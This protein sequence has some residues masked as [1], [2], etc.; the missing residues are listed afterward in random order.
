MEVIAWKIQ[1]PSAGSGLSI[2]NNFR[3]H[4]FYL[5][6]LAL[7][8]GVSEQRNPR[9]YVKNGGF[10]YPESCYFLYG[11]KRYENSEKFNR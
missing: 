3:G 7:V 10:R 2:H 5:S 8:F 4:F 11:M 9:S 6:L 1:N